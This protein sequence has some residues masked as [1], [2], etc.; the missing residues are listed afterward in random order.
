MASAAELLSSQVT[1]ST[2]VKTDALTSAFTMLGAYYN[3]TIATGDDSRTDV[4]AA[5]LAK[6]I[7]QTKRN[8]A[9]GIGSDEFV[10]VENTFSQD[11]LDALLAFDDAIGDSMSIDSDPPDFEDNPHMYDYGESY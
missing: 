5:E 6:K 1:A 7:I 9:K 4:M 8:S 10:T 11:Q 2:A 3:R